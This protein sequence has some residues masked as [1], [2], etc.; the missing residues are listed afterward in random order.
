MHALA[1]RGLRIPEHIS[2]TG[3]DDTPPTT[4]RLDFRAQGREAVRSLLADIEP[5]ARQVSDRPGPELVV[6]DSWGLSAGDSLIRPGSRAGPQRV[7]PTTPTSGS[8][9]VIQ[10]SLDHV[11]GSDPSRRP[12]RRMGRLEAAGP[13]R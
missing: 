12:S 9:R 5:I 6:R 13:K 8:C 2:V 10:G 11:R 1:K 7:S 3:V 4:I